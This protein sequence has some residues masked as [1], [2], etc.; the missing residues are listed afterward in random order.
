MWNINSV[1][2]AQLIG[3]PAQV[4]RR[5]ELPDRSPRDDKNVG[6]LRSAIRPIRSTSKYAVDVQEKM[7]EVEEDVQG[8]RVDVRKDTKTWPWI[9]G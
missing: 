3:R 8:V 7:E 1:P 6:A 9:C 2:P 4:A 5:D